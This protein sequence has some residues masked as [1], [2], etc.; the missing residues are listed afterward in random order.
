MIL[1]FRCYAC[2]ARGLNENWR[3]TLIFTINDQQA[4]T[5]IYAYTHLQAHILLCLV[6]PNQN[7][8][9]HHYLQPSCFAY[10]VFSS[11]Q[12]TVVL[13]VI[14][15]N[16]APTQLQ[17]STAA[18]N[19]LGRLKKTARQGLHSDN[20]MK[21]EKKAFLQG[22]LPVDVFLNLGNPPL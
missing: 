3:I 9:N 11:F 12:R 10:V 15:A 18:L 8:I 5:N 4:C 1:F 17:K 19:L 16:P 7:T 20:C 14:G 13:N 21:E 2:T 6:R 22:K